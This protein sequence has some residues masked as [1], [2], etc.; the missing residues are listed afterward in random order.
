MKI[1]KKPGIK[2]PLAAI[3]NGFI[4]NGKET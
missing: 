1:L 3:A 4:F 2:N